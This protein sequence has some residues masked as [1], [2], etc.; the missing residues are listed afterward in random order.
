MGRQGRPLALSLQQAWLGRGALVR[1]LWPLSLVFGALA[2]VRRT[3][4]RLQILKAERIGVPV[5]VVG[6]VIAGGSGKTP[7]VMAVVR[8]L[9]ARGL[10]TGVVSRGYGRITDDCREVDEDS[11]PCDVGDEPALIRR[12]TGAPVFVARRRAQAARALLAHHPDTC[13]IVSDD[14]LQHLA[15]ARDIEICVFDDRGTGNGWLLPAG[16]LRESW[17]RRCDLVLHTGARPAFAGFSARRSLAGHA[18]RQDGTP[19]PLADLA[20]RSLVA[21]AAIAKPEAFFQMLRERGLV[22][23]QCIALPDH[24]DFADWRAP[25]GDGYALLCTEKDALKLWRRAPDA[26]AVPLLFE[27]EPAFFRALDAKLSSP[28]GPQAA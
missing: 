25:P 18:L 1:L 4:Y 5:I 20:G 3:L 27:P 26:L 16:P 14:G 24:D 21:V 23:Q 10:Q 11:D 2:A 15:L 13:C 6:N 8:H 28:D 17:P 7:V 9:Q 19:V 22:P 12:A